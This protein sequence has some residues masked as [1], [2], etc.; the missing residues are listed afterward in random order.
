MKAKSFLLL[1][2]IVVLIFSGVRIRTGSSSPG[3]TISLIDAVDGDS[4]FVGNPPS[5]YLHVNITIADASVQV[6]AWTIYLSYDT[7]MLYT[8]ESL[9][10]EGDF[11]SNV[12]GT[13]GLQV[14]LQPGGVQI[15]CYLMQAGGATGDGTLATMMFGVVGS[16]RCVI[17]LYDSHLT[18]YPSGT[19]DPTEVDATFYSNWPKADFVYST[20]NHPSKYPGHQPPF[21]PVVNELI[22]FNATAYVTAGERYGG[23]YDPDT[24]T[25]SDPDGTIDSFEWNFGDGNTASVTTPVITHAYDATA[26]YHVTLIVTDN[27]DYTDSEEEDIPVV[28]HD[29]AIIDMEVHPTTISPGELVSIEITVL[30]EGTK[31]NWFNLTCYYDN[32]IIWYNETADPPKREFCLA[33]EKDPEQPQMQHPSLQPDENLTVTFTWNTTGLGKGTYDVWANASLVDNMV[34]EVLGETDTAD[35]TFEGEDVSIVSHDVAVTSVTC[36]SLTATIGDIISIDVTASNLGDFPETFDVTAYYENIDIDTQTVTDLPAGQDTYL[37]FSW[38]TSDVAEG[39]Y[40]IKAQASLLPDET[41][42]TNNIHVDDD[43]T[44][45]KPPGAPVV[46]F[47]Y[48]PENPLV[49]QEVIFNSTSYDEDGYIVSWNWDFNNDGT[50]DSTD[51]N[52][53]WT[54]TE[55]GNYTVRLKVTDNDDIFNNNL[56]NIRVYAPPVANFTYS[57]T[58]PITNQIVTFNASASD[59][60][61]GHIVG[62]KWDFGDGNT[63]SVTNPIIYHT[64]TENR[65]HTVTLNVTDNDGLTD[66]T[67]DDVTVS[68][69]LVHDVA[70]TSVTPNPTTVAPGQYV[71]VT[72]I[73]ENQGDFAE[74]FN[75]TAYYDTNAIGM[76]TV[77]LESNAT[78]S[79]TFTWNTAVVAEGTYTISAEAD[80]V[81]DETDLEDNTYI[82]D[83]VTVVRQVG[84]GQTLSIEFSGE[85]EYFEGDDVKI[86]LVALV[87]YADTMMPASN[88]NV[89]I[90]IFDPEGELWVSNVMVEKLTGTGIYE[91]ESIDTIAELELEKGFYLIHVQA[92]L[93]GLEASEISQFRITTA[94]KTTSI[95]SIDVNPTSVTAGSS[96]TLSGAITPKRPRVTVTIQFRS[97]GGTWSELRTVIT[98]QTGYYSVSWVV[99]TAGTYE[100]KASWLGDT[101]TEG[102]ESEVKTVTVQEGSSWLLE[103]PPYVTVAIAAIVGSIVGSIIGAVVLMRVRKPKPP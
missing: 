9:M 18:L 11:L 56:Q 22:T 52:A 49:N 6:A 70:V 26:T 98:S 88:A 2:L 21:S 73:V 12:A 14:S 53:T 27:N 29:I 74:T 77:T 28:I 4:V 16:G 50:V 45:T 57:P 80:V 43:V 85:R 38:N 90:R 76:E 62:Y 82:D 1:L 19:E 36:S 40:T 47:T 51:E 86:R 64:Y 67:T 25:P 54:Y 20:E 71:S 24:I 33:V 95:I 37:T 100:V 10:E 94:E 72:V 5:D 58:E 3:A 93:G 83:T 81:P 97:S 13:S 8:D 63:T 15:G 87:R 66:I 55:A 92:R 79:I 39:V 75:V 17:D 41:N 84:P 101:R 91:W 46:N 78:E 99:T 44:V 48:S 68:L 35:N 23:S 32:T 65:T 34:Q 69:P 60:P 42:H 102:T 7:G 61:D 96:I 30:N 59:D 31:D 89:T 103:I